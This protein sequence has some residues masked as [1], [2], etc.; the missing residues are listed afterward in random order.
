MMTA[1]SRKWFALAVICVGQFMVILDV[2]IVNVALPSIQ[3]GLHFSEQNLLWVLNA[4]ALMFGGFLMLG[5]RVAD[6]VGRRRVFVTGVVLFT[7]ASLFCGLATSTGWL[8]TAR[9]VQGLGAAILSPAALSILT[10]TFEEGRER[11]TA[12]SIWGAIAGA[13]GAFGVLLGGV[14]TQE[15]GWQWIFYVNV[16][17]GS[18]VVLASIFI[19]APSLAEDENRG[20]D[21][22]GA[23]TLTGG[24]VLMVFALVKSTSWGW[25][26]AKT[27]GTLAVA[28]VVLA[29]FI[30]IERRTKSALVPL[31]T[32][33]N[34]SLSVSN[35]VS[36]AL[37]A[38]IFSMFY[39]LSLYMQQVLGYSALK[40][41]VGYL[42]IA[43]S[44]IVAAGA[45]QSL[46]A[47][48][49]VRLVMTAGMA[50]AAGGLIYFAQI[51]P[52]GTYVGTLLPGFLLAGVGL[53]LSFVPVTIGAM[54]GVAHEEAG[55]ASGL[56]TTTQQIGG[57]LGVAVLST[58]A[59]SATTRF[60]GA[61]GHGPLVAT[62]ALNHGFS[63][64]FWFGAVFAGIGCLIAFFG[65]DRTR[66][67][68]AVASE[69]TLDAS[70]AQVQ[71]VAP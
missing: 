10:V 20:F 58:L 51:S 27:L 39:F 37:G 44:I 63:I 8:I 17:I 42:A 46:V 12:L 41:G 5:G 21:I 69:S 36:L 25:A 32:F 24:L 7:V 34:R 50:L 52:H 3:R 55:V 57:A 47:K 38:S 67:T 35:M 16:P 23:V 66:I 11:N 65:M 18:L 22:P 49:G 15:F 9:A 56:I 48:F 59:V 61:H 71:P 14:L 64:A 26:S 29:L 13:G 28:F 40:T 53:G 43:G 68:G 30:V 60:I 70:P 33:R 54:S 6:K 19:L 31:S 1:N 62:N 4:Y 2:S 45:A